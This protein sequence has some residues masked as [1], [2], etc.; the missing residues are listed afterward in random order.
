MC[1]P[2]FEQH[3]HR[4]VRKL[5][6]S[7][8]SFFLLAPEDNTCLQNDHIGPVL[9]VITTHTPFDGLQ[10]AEKTHEARG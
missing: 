6:R 4:H 7:P 2:C 3:L 1:F 5:V 9:I 8:A 10:L